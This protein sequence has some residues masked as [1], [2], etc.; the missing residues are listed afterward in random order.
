MCRRQP[1]P[2]WSASSSRP[3]LGWRRL[4]ERRKVQPL[5]QMRRPRSLRSHIGCCSRCQLQR[6]PPIAS[7]QSTL[8]TAHH[9]TAASARAAPAHM[10]GIPQAALPHKPWPQWNDQRSERRHRPLQRARSKDAS[11]HTPRTAPKAPRHHLRWTSRH[12]PMAKPAP[13]PCPLT[14]APA[15]P[16]FAVQPKQP[17]QQPHL[18]Q[19]WE[20]SSR[21]S[22]LQGS[23]FHP[24]SAGDG[25][26]VAGQT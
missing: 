14:S 15:S 25:R 3:V 9:P 10:Q 24:R 7:P 11:H 17:G 16:S 13:L 1:Y 4:L 5:K 12:H 23:L 2:V 22:P 18:S 20:H 6:D 26:P 19:T 8:D 21:P